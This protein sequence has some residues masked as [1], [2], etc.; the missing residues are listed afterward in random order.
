MSDTGA[1]VKR[2][3]RCPATGRVF[4]KA[5]FP[6][7]DPPPASLHCDFRCPEAQCRKP[8]HRTFHTWCVLTGVHQVRYDPYATVQQIAAF[9]AAAG[10]EIKE[11]DGHG[12][13]G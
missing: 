3:F 2:W 7:D 1:T 4:G 6:A 13:D 10:I 5:E 9:A 11:D 8:G 12:R